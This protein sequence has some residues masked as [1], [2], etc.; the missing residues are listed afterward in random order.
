M[1]KIAQIRSI[2]NAVFMV[3]AAISLIIYFSK[4]VPTTTFVY[5][6]GASLL[7]KMIEIVLRCLFRNK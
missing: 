1:D 7:V 3:G 2:L 4:G 5:V 6:C